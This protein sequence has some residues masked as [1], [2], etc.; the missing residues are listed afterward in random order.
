MWALYSLLSALGW[1]TSD[2][3]AKKAMQHGAE[4]IRILF[5]RYVLAVPVLLP[6]LGAGIPSLDRTF[7]LLHPVWI[8]LETAAICLY[9]RAIAISPLSLTIPFLS[10][11]PGFLVFTGWFFLGET[12]GLCGLAGIALV[13]AGSYVLNLGHTRRG[14]L[15]PLKAI[16][17]ERGSRLM[18]VV[19]FL[20]S[21]TSI[22]GKVLIQ[23]S[24]P[25]YFAVHYPI[26]MSLVLAPV[27]LKRR[28]DSHARSPRKLILL[29]G[30]FFSMTI[31][32]HMFA[33][34]T[35]KVACMIAL[36]RFSGTFSVLYGWLVFGDRELVYRLAGTIL[37]FA[38][39]LLI[40]LD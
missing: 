25:T 6:F 39:G 17:E 35:A 3:F 38:G 16:L 31:L 29:S 20:Y 13:V 15:G 1:S 22:L 24:S 26:V 27:G 23:H 28:K 5:I 40:V 33:L 21:L 11:T 19:A 12:V 30:L 7:W 18:I 34:E 2:V 10:L 14:W 36:K 32:F 8:P 9:I 4:G 37:M